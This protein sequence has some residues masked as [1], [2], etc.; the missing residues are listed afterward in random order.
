MSM[1]FGSG[2]WDE[3]DLKQ[4][5]KKRSPGPTPNSPQPGSNAKSQDSRLAYRETSNGEK[6]IVIKDSLLPRDF[7]LELHFDEKN[8]PY[9]SRL[10]K[11]GAVS[12]HGWASAVGHELIKLFHETYHIDKSQLIIMS[13]DEKDGLYVWV[14]SRV[15]LPRVGLKDP[16]FGYLPRPKSDDIDIDAN[17]NPDLRLKDGPKLLTPPGSDQVIDI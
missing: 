10:A 7:K 1:F 5:E 3:E 13:S 14:R 11:S 15:Q 4:F 16:N 8:R 2:D 12:A 6:K 17:D 9:T